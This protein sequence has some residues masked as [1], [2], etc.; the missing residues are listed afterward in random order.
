MPWDARMW[1]HRAVDDAVEPTM[2]RTRRVA[3]LLTVAIAL[4]AV[5]LTVLISQRVESEPVEA[6]PTTTTTTTTVPTTTTTT[7]PVPVPVVPVSTPLA[8]PIGEIAVY[9]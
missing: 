7:V 6:A 3:V 1:F 9:D 5:G 2:S 4:F 8:S